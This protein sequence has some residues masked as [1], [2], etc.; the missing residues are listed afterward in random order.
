VPL[1]TLGNEL[2]RETAE[3]PQLKAFLYQLFA[4]FMQLGGLGLLGLGVLDSSFLFMPLGN[5]LLMI[6]LTARHHERLPYYALMATMGSV[7]GC[8]LVDAI[9]RKGGEAG[10]EGRVPQRRLEYVK[11]KVG[12]NAAWALSFAALMPP[13]FPFTPFI[14]AASALQ[15]SRRKL[16]AVVAVSR[17]LRFSAVGLVGI[18]F[19]RRVIALA[20]STGFQYSI[21]ALVAISIL[22][23]ALSVYRWVKRSKHTAA[24]G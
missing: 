22:G 12:N 6:A 2:Q 16:L 17:F 7:L 24:S 3:Q 4:V 15:Y 10:L 1:R 8:M 5:D 9:G 11:R 20:E 14:L 19:G 21:L 18:F 13:P 23:S